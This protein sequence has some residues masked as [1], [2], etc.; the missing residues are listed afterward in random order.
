[1]FPDEDGLSEDGFSTVASG[2][3]HARQ[4]H[5][6]FHTSEYRLRALAAL[7][8][9]ES[10]RQ[11]IYEEAAKRAVN[12]QRDE[13]LKNPLLDPVDENGVSKPN[14]KDDEVIRETA[15]HAPYV[16]VLCLTCMYSF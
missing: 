3:S 11:A 12:A 10:G 2:V 1:M 15:V 4:H 9:S 5:Q 13:R 6:G 7:S 14:A 8:E 16:S